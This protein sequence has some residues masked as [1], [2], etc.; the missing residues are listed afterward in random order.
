MR[1]II[2]SLSLATLGLG[3]DACAKQDPGCDALALR[4]CEANAE[5][6]ARARGWIDAQG[7]G[8]PAARA[9]T[10]SQMLADPSALT[11]Y[12]E[13]F[14]V[15]MGPPPTTGSPRPA[16]QTT[17][18]ATTPP[19]AKPTTADEIR[20]FGDSVEEVGNVGEKAGEAIDK[21]DDIFSRKPDA[22]P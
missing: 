1:T 9:E 12:I 18:P 8:D 7:A 14:V 11:T 21:I 3:V 6:C 13:R 20:T 16:V 4:L 17:P 22:K 15:A 10:C 2:M 19:R 5:H